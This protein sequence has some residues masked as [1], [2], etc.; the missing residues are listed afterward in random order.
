MAIPESAPEPGRVPAPRGTRRLRRPVP[1]RARDRRPGRGLRDLVLA[2]G[3]VVVVVCAVAA[4]AGAAAQTAT[5]LPAAVLATTGVVA[6]L[7]GVLYAGRRRRT[8]RPA[9]ATGPVPAA[10]PPPGPGAADPVLFAPA[11][12]AEEATLV[13]GAGTEAVTAVTAATAVVERVDY[14]ALDPD[15]FEQAVAALCERD[16]CWD[17][18]VVGGAAD[19]GADVVAT[20]P[21]GRRLVIQCKCYGPTHKVGSQDLQRF[22]G[23]CFAIH[24]A[25]VAALVT[26]SEFTEP[27]LGYAEQCGILCLDGAA[28]DAWSDG[29]GPA[30]WE[31][32]APEGGGPC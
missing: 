32:P 30:P 23:T 18:E 2:V 4:T 31:L 9:A 29:S 19:L 13:P 24:E 27:A 8:R 5:G 11:P 28:L 22:G 16:G 12:P 17:V 21:D 1:G 26:T 7:A 14:A 20:A 3:L 15:A 6:V 25:G 10:A